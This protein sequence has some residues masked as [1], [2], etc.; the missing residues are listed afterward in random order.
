MTPR[1]SFVI[2]AHNGQSYLREAIDSCLGQTIKQI[3]V[4]VVNDGSNDGTKEL[5]DYYASKDERV[6]PV[7]LVENVGRSEARNIGNEKAEGE[8]IM[9]LDADDRAMRNRTK[10]TLALFAAKKPDFIYGGFI[11]IDTFGNMERR[12]APTPF[13]RQVSLKYKTHG[14]CHST[15]AYRKGLTRNIQYQGGDYSRLGI[16]DWRFI[17]DA[18]IKGYKFSYL[19]SPLT[20]YRIDPNSISHTRDEAE[21]SKVKEAFLATL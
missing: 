7:H 6:K 19:K 18:H 21:V 16:D 13:S 9:V 1:A 14:I 3:E 10:D 20:Y 2:P 12:Y 5:L 4:I 17:W 15:V 8:I 11:T